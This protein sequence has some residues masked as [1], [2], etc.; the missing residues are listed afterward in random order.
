MASR[1]W[2]VNSFTEDVETSDIDDVGED[3]YFIKYYSNY[4]TS[5]RMSNTKKS[6]KRY[7]T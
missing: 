6:R 1:K 3:Q 2:N 4:L 5:Y 7:R